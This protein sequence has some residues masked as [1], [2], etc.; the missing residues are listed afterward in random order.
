[1]GG[2]PDPDELARLAAPYQCDAD[3]AAT[4]PL[5]ERLGLVW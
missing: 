1:M 5:V 3:V 2:E 4:M